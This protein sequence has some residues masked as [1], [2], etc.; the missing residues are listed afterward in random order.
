LG[1]PLKLCIGQ[2]TVEQ[3]PFTTPERPSGHV[4]HRDAGFRPYFSQWLR[5]SV[6]QKMFNP[7]LT[8]T[9]IRQIRATLAPGAS[10]GVRVKD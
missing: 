2:I 3:K 6:V 9:V 8:I 7:L 5:A 10:A 4:S 1:D